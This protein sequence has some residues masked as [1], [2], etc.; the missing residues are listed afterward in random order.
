MTLNQTIYRGQ[1]RGYTK[2]SE[3]DEQPTLVVP[4]QAVIALCEWYQITKRTEDGDYIFPN[5]DGGFLLE[6]NYLR[7]VLKE[8]AARAN[9]TPKIKKLNFQVLRRTVASHAADLGSLKSVQAIM[10]H[11]QMQTTQN[12]YVQAIDASV[13]A[14]GEALASKML[15]K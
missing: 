10:R 8:L 7:R 14:T 4:E 5:A 9:V 6:G 11:K 2:T 15:N 12:I 1:V 13:R 3:E